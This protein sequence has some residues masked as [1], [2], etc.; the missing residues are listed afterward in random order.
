[1]PFGVCKLCQKCGELQNSH[2]LPK[3]AYR[4]NRAPQLNNP[5]P[6]VLSN[7]ELLQSSAQL[8]DYLL[9]SDCEQRFSKNGESWVLANIPRDYGEK[10]TVF[11]VLNAEVAIWEEGGNKA[12]AGANVKS[13][14]MEKL[15]YFAVS[16]FWRGAV[17]VWESSLHSRAHDVQLFEYEEPI[18]KFLLGTAPLSEDVTV[19]V[20][21]CPNGRKLNAMLVPWAAHLPQCSR[22]IFYISGLGFVLQFAHKLGPHF[23]ESCAH[24]SPSKVIFVSIEFE[25]AIKDILREEV[26]GRDSSRVQ[27]MLQEIAMIR[28]KP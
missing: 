18:R 17:H 16:V 3:A 4:V 26:K 27:K 8:S 10:F 11:D 9:C 1:M 7:N 5:H 21:V 12:Y 23:R 2:Y 28:S 15:V 22:Y 20:Y 19:A 13:L 24:H 14:D 6:V 25:K